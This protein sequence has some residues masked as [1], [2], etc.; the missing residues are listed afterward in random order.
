MIFCDFCALSP[1][2]RETL[3]AGFYQFLKPDGSLLLDVHSLNVFNSREEISTYERNQLDHFWSPEDYY[4]F[5]NTF[6]YDKEKITLDKYTIIEKER[7]RV[8]YNWLQYF[9]QDTLREEFEQNGFE[10]DA[11]YADVAGAA[12]SPQSPD[13]AIVASKIP[14]L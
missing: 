7:T 9:S 11:I 14:R 3:L 1:S 4:G 2:Q 10:A 13:M 8:I 5:L 6:K 12:F